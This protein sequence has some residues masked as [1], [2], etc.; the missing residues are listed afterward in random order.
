MFA[1]KEKKREPFDFAQD[2]LRAEKGAK[3]ILL[4]IY[5]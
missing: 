3:K 4:L 5:N 2:K 1:M